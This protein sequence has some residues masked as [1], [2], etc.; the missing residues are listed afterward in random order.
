VAI[1]AVI[2]CVRYQ[3]DANDDDS[4]QIRGS[5]LLETPSCLTILQLGIGS[6]TSLIHQPR[7]SSG[8]HLAISSSRC[9]LASGKPQVGGI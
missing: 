1:P 6:L 9:N 8:S 5:R 4:W 7:R 3:I 2:T